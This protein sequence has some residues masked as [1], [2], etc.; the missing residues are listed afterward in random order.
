MT[1]LRVS[2]FRF[3]MMPIDMTGTFHLALLENLQYLRTVH[4]NVWTVIQDVTGRR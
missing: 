2:C 4:I 3:T 1:G